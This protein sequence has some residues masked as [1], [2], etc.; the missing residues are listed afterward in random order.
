[1]E[2]VIL[3]EKKTRGRSNFL[4]FLITEYFLSGCTVTE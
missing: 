4:P 3:A 1:M 2:A